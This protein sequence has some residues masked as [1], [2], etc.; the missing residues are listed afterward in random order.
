MLEPVKGLIKKENIAKAETE[1]FKCRFC[2]KWSL[3]YFVTLKTGQ[4][5]V[6]CHKCGSV[7]R[8]LKL[9]RTHRVKTYAKGRRFEY[10]I[11]K[12]L[13]SQGYTVFRFASSKPLDLVAIRNG[14]VMFIECKATPDISLKDK[15]KLGEWSFKLGYPVALFLKNGS[16]IMV[17]VFEGKP[18][19]HWRNT[20]ELLDNFM[21]FLYD[22][23]WVSEDFGYLDWEKIIWKFLFG[24]DKS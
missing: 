20:F 13:E 16:S 3:I 10:Q 11:K 18:R 12:L 17:E 6:V 24:S 19:R 5:I 2:G 1:F 8:T 23:H 14:K 15:E 4:K 22:K 21:Q 7:H 9:S